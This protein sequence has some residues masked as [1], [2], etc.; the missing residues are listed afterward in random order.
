MNTVKLALLIMNVLF[1][2]F[3]PHSAHCY[4]L[5]GINNTFGSICENLFI[6]AVVPKS[7]EQDD[8]I[9]PNTVVPI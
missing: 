2:S 4:F 3:F 9:P 8:H 5:N 7:G 1:W 6:T